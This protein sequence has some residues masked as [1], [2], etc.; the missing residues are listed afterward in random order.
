MIGRIETW[1]A[2]AGILI[3]ID[4]FLAW[5]LYVSRIRSDIRSELSDAQ[6]QTLARVFS[7]AGD[8]AAKDMDPKVYLAIKR[9]FQFGAD[10]ESKIEG[11]MPMERLERKH[12]KGLKSGSTV[13]RSEAIFA[14]G[15]LGTENARTALEQQLLTET[16]FTLKLYLANA[17]SDIGNDASLPVLIR[18][19]QHASRFYRSRV[20]MLIAGFGE[21]FWALLPRLR[22][23][24]KEEIRE[25]L[26]DFASVYDSG[27]TKQYLLDI[28]EPYVEGKG[29]PPPEEDPPAACANCGAGNPGATERELHCRFRGPV[30][31]SFVCRRYRNRPPRIS[32]ERTDYEL[33]VKA[34][35][36]LSRRH[37]S[38][39]SAERYL[40]AGDPEIRKAAI[41]ALANF[42]GVDHVDK[43]LSLLSE[44][45][46][47]DNAAHALSLMAEQDPSL[48]DRL[49]TRFMGEGTQSVKRALAEILALRIEYFIA[50]LEGDKKK[51]SEHILEEILRAGR[52]SEVIDFLNSNKN[53]G[54]E[55]SLLAIVRRC[56]AADPKLKDHFRTYFT[57]RLRSLCD[58]G[59]PA[60]YEASPAQPPDRTYL[61]V[62]AVLLVLCFLLVPGVF[63]VVHRDVLGELTLRPALKLFVRD[64]NHYFVYYAVAINSVYFTLMALSFAYVR[65]QKRSWQIKDRAFLF[66]PRMLP[67]ITV[68]APAFNEARTII[69][70][71]NS[72]MNLSYPD[73]ELIIVNDGSTDQTLAV[74]QQEFGLKRVD[75]VYKKELETKEVK[76]IYL[77]RNLPKLVVVDK[78]NGGKADALNA[79][80]NVA[81][82]EYICSI[83]ADSILEEDALLKLVSRI[84]EEDVETPAMG[85]NV[86]PIN[87]CRVERGVIRDRRIPQN[88]LALLQTIEYIRAFMCGRLGWAF[89][90]NLLIISG[91]FGLFRKERGV[92]VGG[93]L[94]SSGQY[95]KDT[96]GEDM[97]IVVRISRQMREAGRPYR[98][99]YAF[100][101]NCWTEVPEDLRSL[102]KQRYRWQRGL[103]EI[104][105]FHKRM[106]LNYRYGRTGMIA[107]PY[108]FFFEVL[109][110]LFEVQGYIAVFLA[111]VLG[112]LYWDV[113]IM[114][115]V[116]AIL[117][118][119]IISISSLLVAEHGGKLFPLKDTARLI[120][121][122]FLENFGFRQYFSLI[123]ATGY[124]RIFKGVTGWEKAE[125]KGFA[126]S[127]GNAGKGPE[128]AL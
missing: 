63:L 14:L 54:L 128:G 98:I 90:N 122:A 2:I 76:G 109:G 107:M 31:S 93:Y 94:T 22:G 27:E 123:R 39:I 25:L 57:P 48:P 9:T 44:E 99:R 61:A 66:K 117:S 85:G 91:A 73:Y 1:F 30:E 101:A 120:G 34:C 121:W 115:F 110:P 113:A 82:R 40:Y 47:R 16:N 108:Y 79:G 50:R 127:S 74:L 118:G 89:T 11:R 29:F 71:V 38:A 102:R 65:R 119:T 62:L 33:M 114:L 86:F 106:L 81:S 37:P 55:G 111:A 88:R 87:G 21:S 17:L 100:N 7:E 46:V 19:L 78:V 4:L 53:P 32:S 125:R 103:I 49:A 35:G 92:R 5:S 13:R 84:L 59:E 69:E 72:L 15:H 10:W 60:P 18:S 23:S 36:I 77:N 28:L 83:D 51:E 97:E 42:R 3:V 8:A 116:A 80:I 24:R 112:V 41:S 12:I 26:V 96:V 56:T 43:L 124:F 68:V 52:V 105:Y 64:F 104:L 6:R 126:G 58:P 95:G 70:N 75:R 20:N 67:S 45:A